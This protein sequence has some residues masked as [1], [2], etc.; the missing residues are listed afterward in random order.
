MGLGTIEVHAGDF[1]KGKA[2]QLAGKWL[3]MKSPKRFLREKISVGDLAGVEVATE[4]SVKRLAGTVGWGAAGALL[5]GPV[6]LLAGLLVGGRGKRVTFVATLK[7]GRRFL[8][9]TD[10]KTYTNLAAAAF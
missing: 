8:G 10:S 2:S 5:L 4:E 3:Y 9:S 1:V 6:G 7:D